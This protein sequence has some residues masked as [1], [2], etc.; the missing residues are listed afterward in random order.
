MYRTL[1][2][3]LL[4]ALLA[5]P[6]S[7]Q[8]I[9]SLPDGSLHPSGRLRIHGTGFGSSGQVDIGGLDAIVT[10]WTE[11]AIHAYVPET[12][13]LGVVPVQVH[14][15]T[16][17]SNVM[18]LEVTERQADGR[19]LWRFQADAPRLNPHEAAVAADG[20]VYIDDIWGRLYAI[21]PDGG[22]AWVFDGNDGQPGTGGEGPVSLLTDGTI[23]FA[24]NP[25]GQETR[26][27]AVHPNGT[28]RWLWSEFSLAY[29]FCAGPDVGPDGNIYAVL[30]RAH[31]GTLGAFSLDPNGNLRWSNQGD[32]LIND[33][34]TLGHRIEFSDDAFF[35]A[36]DEQQVPGVTANWMFAFEFN[37]TQR[38][39]L[40]GCA[41][42][43]RPHV[44]PDHSILVQWGLDSQI[45]S[46]D[47]NGVTQWT[48]TTSGNLAWPVLDGLGNA[49][50]YRP[51]QKLQSLFPD[52]T[53]RWAVTGPQLGWPNFL[54]VSP[55]SSVL[56]DGGR[57]NFGEPGWIRGYGADNG[58]L[59]WEVT[60]PEEDMGG[61]IGDLV[62]SGEPSF[63]AD[64]SRVYSPVEALVFDTPNPYSYLYAVSLEDPP[65]ETFCD[66]VAANSTGQPVRLAG[67]FGST[68]GSGLHLE[69]QGGPSG[70]F[71]YFLVG[72]GAESTNP[73]PLGMGW[74]CLSVQSGEW[75]TRYNV[76]A[77]AANSLGR[78]DASGVLQNQIGTSS[79]GSGF[80]VP[81]V[82]PTLGGLT[83]TSGMTLHFQLWYRDSAAAPGAS[84]LSDALTVRF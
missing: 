9:T 45:R 19:L 17:S 84:N 40:P 13:A 10:T 27:N 83:I 32:P 81:S 2:L 3:P 59:L 80:D 50:L 33:E 60:L 75:I 79:V 31:V 23:I 78:F 64:S 39:S 18:P 5:L 63:P 58:D 53:E 68:P 72:S 20:T 56:C 8:T 42:V 69:A 82:V 57:M 12:V 77:S 48:E 25:L 47:E 11:T 16:G 34:G 52:G 62:V 7:A 43:G 61:A 1:A 36:F 22:L 71:G 21:R 44:R 73:N 55:D 30:D 37:G 46:L 66:A 51:V 38:W 35:V 54:G 67:E 15:S 76:L 4:A 70:E 41:R 26:I 49:F 29:R 24:T 65:I 74:L 28:R 6:T 14:A